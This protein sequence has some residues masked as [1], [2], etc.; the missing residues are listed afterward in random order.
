MKYI[1]FLIFMISIISG[2]SNDT[3][4]VQTHKRVHMN[5]WGSYNSWGE[6]P[7]ET[8]TFHKI[9]M[10]Y[11]LGCPDGG[12]S[13][14]DYTTSISILKRTGIM[15]SSLIQHPSFKVDNDILETFYFNLDTT[16]RYE[17]NDVSNSIDTIPNEKKLIRIFDNSEIPDLQTDSLTVW[18]A[19]YYNFLFDNNGDVIDSSLVVH[20]SVWHV[21][22]INEYTPFEVIEPYEIGRVMTPYSGSY[23]TSN[24]QQKY[25][26]DATDFSSLLHDSV[27]IRVFYGG[28]SDGF[29][30]NVEFKMIKGTPA[31]EAYKIENLWSSGMGGFKYG[32]VDNPIENK[33]VPRRIYFD[34]NTSSAAVRVT[35]SGHSFGGNENCAE[36]CPKECYLKINDEIK[37]T[38]LMWRDDCG[39][40]PI[41]PQG[42]TWIYDRAG[43]C[44][45]LETLIF[46]NEIIEFVTMNDSNSIDLDFEEYIYQGGAGFD[47]N[48]IVEA[49]LVYYKENK[50]T[51][52]ASIVDIIA[53]SVNDYH[54]RNNPI[55][56]NP[57]IKVRNNG[58]NEI[59]SLTIVYGVKGNTQPTYNWTGSI[60]YLEEV[61]I[62]LPNIPLP[63]WED[64][65]QQQES[66]FEVKLVYVNDT[67]SDQVEYNNFLSSTFESIQVFPDEFLLDISTNNA[68]DENYYQIKELVTD[69][70]ILF[71]NDLENSTKYIDTMRLN[72]GCYEFLIHDT[73]GDGIKFWAND[74]GSGNMSIRLIDD[75][76]LWSRLQSDFGT[77]F[78][79]QFVIS[80]PP[81]SVD[82]LDKNE[83]SFKIYPNPANEN[84]SLEHQLSNNSFVITNIVG[85]RVRTI[86]IK[87][88]GT[89]DINTTELSNGLYFVFP[90]DRTEEVKK[91]IIQH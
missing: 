41:Y 89:I 76:L 2:F 5:W 12:C 36:F 60:N 6:F 23:S 72:P 90:I 9:I 48:Y 4:F 70:I 19:N 47:P 18:E 32:F 52:D 50:Y 31:R 29:T 40:N 20:D 66:I 73:G 81:Y 55:C 46:K 44:P 79:K 16:Y 38:D 26:F 67:W 80:P 28:W 42:G 65:E 63:Y 45:G 10:E 54:T 74:A 91:L 77:E 7:P 49:Q 35:S 64:G 27:E 43:W 53:P 51:T 22:Y 39:L 58:L 84:I 34:E 25:I 82:F 15:D 62:S 69:S 83:G 17:Y 14:W 59:T 8:E 3:I 78:R 11:T 57:V 30:A 33:L 85:Q 86:S 71:R 87:Q 37:F 21:T 68:A 61:E 24:W 75:V 88:P 1:P 13:D 56:G